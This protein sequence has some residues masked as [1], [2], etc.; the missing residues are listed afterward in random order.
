MRLHRN[1][2]Y[3]VIDGLNLIFNEDKYADKVVQQLLKRDKRWGSRDR[4]FI[5]ET[6][7]DIVRWKRLYGEIA[8]VKEPFSRENLWR[9]FA[10]WA[11][12][13]GIQLPDWKQ[14]EG[15][16][17]RRIKGRFD[18][19]SKIRKCRE[20]IPD[21]L[22][23]MGSKELGEAT[24]EK[25]L[26]ALNQ[27]AEVVI[28]V[29]TLK[30]NKKALQALLI[31]EDIA[32]IAIKNYPDALQ[33]KERSNVFKTEA[34]KNGLFEVQDA[35]SQLIA[36][37]LD[38]KPGMRIA[39]ACAGAGG[40]SLH[41]AAKMDN[42]GQ[43]IAMDIYGFKL[44]ELKRRAKRNGAHNIEPREIT[45][46]KTIKKLHNQMDRVLIDAPCSGLG[47]LR[48]NPDAKWKL[49]PEFIDNIKKTQ[50]EILRDYSKMVKPGG[51][52]VYATCSILP[53]ENQDQVKAFL[54]SENGK[55][56]GLVKDKKVLAST[57]GFDGFYM[58]LLAKK[59]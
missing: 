56:F 23:D 43:I 30:T 7:Y 37:F 50:Q 6:T 19:L 52:M 3:A 13:K 20:S 58:A 21:W 38:V 22:D 27:Q 49:K 10:V 51:K 31:D 45:S 4:G 39:D 11:T 46:T 40:K 42:K 41:L 24:W 17:S 26:K 36:D 1:L 16:P 59:Q 35:S 2:V 5:A 44:K 15:T 48:R 33:L 14:L 18:E 54:Q 34:F 32:T 25:E 57:S 53:S 8:E 9:I 12:L 28:R 47:V 55:D 29:N